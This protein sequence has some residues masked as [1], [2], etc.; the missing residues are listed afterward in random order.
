M[1]LLIISHTP[2]YGNR[3]SASGWASTVREIDQIATLFDSVC[4]LAPLYSGPATPS[5]RRYAAG[6]V[7]FRPVPPA[8]G[9]SM[10]D[11]FRILAAY[12]SYVK[13][14][15]EEMRQ[16]D[17]VHVRC[18]ANIAMCGLAVLKSSNW[19]GPL[20]IKYAGSWAGYAGEPLSY[21]AQRALLRI[22]WIN[23]SVTVN[24]EWPRQP[25]H[26]VPLFNPCFTDWELSEARAAAQGKRLEA[27]LR[28]LFA[29]RLD[30]DKGVP[31]FLR[32]VAELN[33]RGV[34]VEGELAGGGPAMADYE[35]MASRLAIRSRVTFLGWLPRPVLNEAYRRAHFIVLPSR[36]EGWPKVLSEA[37]AYGAVPLA[38]R[39]GSIPQYLQSFRSGAAL[40]PSDWREFAHTIRG[41]SVEPERWRVESEAAIRAA[42]NFS[43]STY[44]DSVRKLFF[45]AAPAN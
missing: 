37:M 36:A 18:P 22:P 43:Y 16:S 35:A 10:L 30:G 26:V 40:E 19:Q 29:G 12:P 33:S 44:V 42:L 17:A 45:P 28:L 5:F 14:I 21:L 8:G 25:H 3:E 38:G 41:Y 2:H 24:G 13:A 23:A 32:V 9:E 39:V 11:K 4:H 6:N 15:R 1:R 7:R 20:W 27:P 31:Q 34:E